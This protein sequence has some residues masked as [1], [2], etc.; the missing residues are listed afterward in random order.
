MKKLLIIDDSRTVQA[1]LIR[2]MRGLFFV[3]QADSILQAEMLF[4]DADV[5]IIDALLPDNGKNFTH[6]ARY[7]AE[8]PAVCYT[9]LHPRDIGDIGSA[10]YI[11]KSKTGKV[12]LL[13][14]LR[15]QSER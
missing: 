15:E 5:L 10:T 8:K 11:S 7:A 6:I 12:Q 14:W 13:K 1:V 3:S 9:S 2:E 4:R